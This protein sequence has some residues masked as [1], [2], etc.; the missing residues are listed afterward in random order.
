MQNSY[1]GFRTYSF[2]HL[3]ENI[4]LKQSTVNCIY[5]DSIGLMYFGTNEG[6]FLYDGY[7]SELRW[8]TIDSELMLK[9]NNIYSIA[10]FAHSLVLLSTEAGIYLYNPV[11]HRFSLVELPFDD[12]GKISFISS[13]DKLYVYSNKGLGCLSVNLTD[14]HYEATYLSLNSLMNDWNSSGLVRFSSYTQ[15]Q[16]GK[17]LLAQR[18]GQ[19]FCFTPEEER[20]ERLWVQ[21]QSITCIFEDSN[22]VVWLGS[23]NNRVTSWQPDMP[24][25]RSFQL[26]INQNSYEV[27]KYITAI[28][29]DEE[30][31][32][33]IGTNNNGIALIP[34]AGKYEYKP[35]IEYYTVESGN[36]NSI[37]DN[38]VS[39]LFCERSNAIFIGTKGNGINQLSLGK[40]CFTQY[41]VNNNDANS[42]DHFRVNAIYE[43]KE[44]FIW[45]GTR[46]GLNRY[47]KASG[48]YERFSNKVPRANETRPNGVEYIGE[49]TC[50]CKDSDGNLWI[51]TYGSG[52]YRYDYDKKQFFHYEDEQ[53]NDV[54]ADRITDITLDSDN[55]LWLA[56]HSAG[57]A[58]ILG[59]DSVRNRLNIRY[60]KCD[61][62]EPNVSSS[63]N[64]DIVFI[65]S[66]DNLWFSHRDNGL[67]RLGKESKTMQN[68]RYIA[69]D[70]TSLSNNTIISV[71]DDNN[72]DI[73]FGT[74]RGLNKFDIETELFTSYTMESGLPHNSICGV[75]SDDRG[76]IWLYTQR[77]IYRF[78]PS[79]KMFVS[80][81]E[82]SRIFHEDYTIDASFKNSSGKLYLGTINNGCFAFHPDS[83]SD[84]LF[85][86]SVSFTN[87]HM[88]ECAAPD[89]D[90]AVFSCPDINVDTLNLELTYKQNNFS[91]EYTAFAYHE[92]LNLQ[93][94]YH[95]QG[96]DRG[97]NK[98]NEKKML[99]P[100][101]N[102]SPGKYVFKVRVANQLNPGDYAEKR[103]NIVIKPPFYETPLAYS[104]YAILLLLIVFV[105]YRYT[106]SRIKLKN[107]LHIERMK[108]G[109]FTNVSHEFRTPLTLI[110][111][112]LKKLMAAD[113][114]MSEQERRAHYSLINR[115]TEKMMKLVNQ[116]LDIRKIDN[117]KMVLK[118]E[119]T[120]IIPFTKDIFD[121]FNLLA[122]EK[123]IAYSFDAPSV[124]INMACDQ[125]KM[126]KILY[127]LI[128]NA[129]KYTPV[130]GSISVNIESDAGKQLC[131]YV[132][133]T[134]KGIPEDKMNCI[135]EWFYQVE[136]GKE[137]NINGTGLGLS[138]VKSFVEM[139][140]GKVTVHNNE[141]GCTFV[142]NLPLQDCRVDE[143][144]IKKE[145]GAFRNKL[146]MERSADLSAH[147]Y[148]DHKGTELNNRS[149]AP[150][151]LV[152]EDND[153]V[154]EFI[155]NQLWQNYRIKSATNGTEGLEQAID[156]VPDLIVSDIMMPHMDG[157]ELCKQLKTD[158]RTSHI[159]VILLSARSSV[160]Q[161]IQGIDI[162]ADAYITKP[163]EPFYLEARIKNLIASR[164]KLRQ[165]F[166]A[167][168]DSCS[169]M[170][171]EMTNAL[172]TDFLNKVT[173]IVS[174]HLDDPDF[175]VPDLTKQVGMSNTVFYLKLKAL[176]GF[177]AIE[178]IRHI[179]MKKAKELLNYNSH[180]I[181]EVSN[182]VGFN[183]PKYFSTCFKRMYGVSPSQYVYK[184][185]K[186]ND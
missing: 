15:S 157:F 19:V 100:Y 18:D 5:Q 138:I 60:Y 58:R 24:W 21:Q 127:N 111:G 131:I 57:I 9:A 76:K 47:H 109:F 81:I 152:V 114:G 143:S 180:T 169:D 72:G 2:R 92:S 36:S 165:V 44:G 171:G 161:Q 181:S 49:T 107:D 148:P 25:S 117:Q 82:N 53:G 55:N 173:S 27:A 101:T 42:L 94:S 118:T 75:L 68:F 124:Q 14:N 136:Q 28:C 130:K 185:T 154:R 126:E 41:V 155:I 90:R 119:Q 84:N 13:G 172:D 115:N 96:V 182:I 183:D 122:Q 128:S 48:R 95:M 35:D 150:L 170:A 46:L 121:C 158:I 20:I 83:I 91:I 45:F 104:I 67:F 85:V 7:S 176:T 103:M 135:F 93:F 79:T 17:V 86:P 125:D 29:E 160:E 151:I 65:D 105:L 167:D 177:S 22:G 149:D 110:V 38:N 142:V 43:D 74:A 66:K 147:H 30:G 123:Q 134:G 70:S 102:L 112:P 164:Q 139:H 97:W 89:Q 33:I 77:G 99:I 87:F 178:F 63:Q 162:G 34:S 8:N 186:I 59:V 184:K 140:H 1:A 73:W 61:N 12:F 3:T 120:D 133:D 6:L 146:V 166:K 113:E 156:S 159:P 56:T 69:G 175:S 10:H 52:L 98:T 78:D 132:R 137:A 39:Y 80:F 108:L 51:G 141:V 64:V 129:F 31:N 26:Q 153:E 174:D 145:A 50:F 40:G 62:T 4:A 116:I 16:S 88:S 54:P 163:F 106:L 11:T 71:C 168:T 23:D 179:R 144:G 37:C 32:I